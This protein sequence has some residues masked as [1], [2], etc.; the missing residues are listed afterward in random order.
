MDKQQLTLLEGQK[1]KMK[2]IQPFIKCS[3]RRD[4]TAYFRGKVIELAG[5]GFVSH[6]IISF[7][8]RGELVQG[9]YDL[10][11]RQFIEEEYKDIKLV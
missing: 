8:Y 4:V 10:Y 5:P 2:L 3:G 9:M 6:A 11:E 1:V 7:K